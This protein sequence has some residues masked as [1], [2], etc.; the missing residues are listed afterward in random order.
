MPTFDDVRSLCLALPEVEEVLTWDTDVTFRVRGKIFVI[1]GDGA[2]AISI[3]AT[4]DVQA[5]LIDLDAATF[6][7]AAY[8]GRFGWVVVDL[9]RVDPAMLPGLLRDAWSRTAPKRHPGRSGHRSP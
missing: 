8:V 9:E 3:K 4:P 5:E 2:T 6:R 1:G 7:K